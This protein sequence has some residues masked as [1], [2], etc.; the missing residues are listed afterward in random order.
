MSR[1]GVLVRFVVLAAATAAL[2]ACAPA[3]PAA[4]SEPGPSETAVP[5]VVAAPGESAIPLGCAD[6]LD[7]AAVAD[8]GP[9]FD[10]PIAVAVD[11]TRIAVDWSVA[12]L[13][14][15]ALHCV[16][17]SRYAASDFHAEIELWVA[18]TTATALDAASESSPIGD[19]GVADGV[20]GAI[21]A[22]AEAF[23]ATEAPDLFTSCDAVAIVAGYRVEV[24]TSGLTSG[25]GRDPSAT[26]SILADIVAAVPSAGPART[27][28]PS[29]ASGT[30]AAACTSPE[31]APVLA[32]FGAEGAPVVG[33]DDEFPAVTSCRWDVEGE[34]GDIGL[35]VE[36]LPGGA[37]ALPRLA[38]GVSTFW[39]PTAPSA[40]GTFLI[41]S[42]DS[43]SGWRTL[44]DDL[45]E[46][47]A[48][49]SGAARDG[50]AAFLES[51]W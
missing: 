28:A 23:R 24:A 15:G 4:T 1:Q 48:S 10:D 35:R 6:L 30:P 3:E 47:F 5:V 45:V 13:Q 38:T 46:V 32:Y 20:P 27:V 25:P 8:L 40:D 21:V 11:E 31:L 26:T 2:A 51:T 9:S 29:A 39:V 7:V 18:P 16:W 41:G 17:A 22:C 49:P 44:G 19:F 14:D 37:W 42:G 43:V 50:W 36:V 34:F 33:T 12:R